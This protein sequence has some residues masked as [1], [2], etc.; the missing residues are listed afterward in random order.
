MPILHLIDGSG[1]NCMVDSPV[2]GANPQYVP[3]YDNY[4]PYVCVQT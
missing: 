2:C 1:K 4:V 3:Q